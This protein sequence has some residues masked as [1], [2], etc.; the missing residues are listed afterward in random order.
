[1]PSRST[2]PKGKGGAGALLRP[3]LA[4]LVLLIVAGASVA[5]TWYLTTRNIQQNAAQV[6]LG[7]GQGGAAGAPGA[8]GAPGTPVQAT[9]VPPPTT[10]PVVP[11]PIFIPL[12]A[13]TV[14]LQ[15]PETERILHVGLTLR[16][17]DDQ[18]RQRIEKYMPEVRSRIL[19]TLSAQSPQAVQTAQGKND[20][21][22]AIAQ[23][24]NRP[25]SPLPDGQ[26]VTDV[27]FTAF[28]VQ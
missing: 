12:E 15:S 5:V 24:V 28:V 26:Y 13:F 2:L 27:L 21:A 19:M 8:P 22:A 25:F 16:V 23:T 9:F 10:P 7:V 1:M 3:L 11:A 6:Q 17:S 20:L 4:L 14:T 18:T